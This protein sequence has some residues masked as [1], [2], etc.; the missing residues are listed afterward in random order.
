MV[1]ILFFPNA[2]IFFYVF[3]RE[4]S[5][6]S[7]KIYGK[8]LIQLKYIE[9]DEIGSEMMIKKLDIK[10]KEKFWTFLEK[11]VNVFVLRKKKLKNKQI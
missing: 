9:T 8:V 7:F 6:Y 3:K 4:N 5:K 1:I 2:K 10:L 11:D